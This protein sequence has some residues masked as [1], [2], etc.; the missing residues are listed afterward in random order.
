MTDRRTIAVTYPGSNGVG[1]L[2]TEV[3]GRW[4][5]ATR[6]HRADSWSAP[7]PVT[8][9]ESTDGEWWSDVSTV[10]RWRLTLACGHTRDLEWDTCDGLPL[11]ASCDICQVMVAI[12]RFVK[13]DPE[14]ERKFGSLAV[15]LP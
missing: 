15:E 8:V 1:L 12:S 10:N 5:V 7:C 9:E 6:S 2:L 13:T 11:T 14:L 4:S 3:D